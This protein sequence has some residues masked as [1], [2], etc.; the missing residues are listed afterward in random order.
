MA[1]VDRYVLVG[2]RIVSWGLLFHV[3]P[4]LTAVSSSNG[5]ALSSVYSLAGASDG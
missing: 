4:L 1:R 5:L 3:C 2:E